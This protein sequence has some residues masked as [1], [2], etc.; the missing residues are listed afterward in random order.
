MGAGPKQWYGREL[1]GAGG[2]LL[3]LLL[4]GTGGGGC[5]DVGVGALGAEWNR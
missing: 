2:G 4:V 5:D 3:L 1:A